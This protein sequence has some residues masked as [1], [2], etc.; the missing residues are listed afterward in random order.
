MNTCSIIQV[1]SS[2]SGAKYKDF[3]AFS[4]KLLIKLKGDIDDEKEIYT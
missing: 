3:E 2:Y 1:N 4:I